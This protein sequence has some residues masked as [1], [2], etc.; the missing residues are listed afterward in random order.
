MRVQIVVVLGHSGRGILGSYGAV[1]P[2]F[3]WKCGIAH[4]LTLLQ[5]F[6][7][8]TANCGC[9]GLII[10]KTIVSCT[11]SPPPQKKY[12]Q[13]IC[14][15]LWFHI[16]QWVKGPHFNTTR[17]YSHLEQKIYIVLNF[18]THFRGLGNTVI[19]ERGDIGKMESKPRLNTSWLIPPAHP[20]E[21]TS[22]V[23]FVQNVHPPISESFIPI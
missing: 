7:S 15:E 23:W 18:N 10:W 19:T 3:E 1:Q 17:S 21:L 20:I 5:E 13:H 8:F 16:G 9:K 22:F 4:I 11:N 2:V 14:Y 12:S 6:Y